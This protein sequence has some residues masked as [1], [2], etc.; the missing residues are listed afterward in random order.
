MTNRLLILVA[1]LAAS[2]AATTT[3]D[4]FVGKFTYFKVPAMKGYLTNPFTYPFHAIEERIQARWGANFNVWWN[5]TGRWTPGPYYNIAPGFSASPWL[6]D[7]TQVLYEYQAALAVFNISDVDLDRDFQW[8]VDELAYRYWLKGR[9]E[10]GAFAY[11]LHVAAKTDGAV[12]AC[13]RPVK[14]DWSKSTAIKYVGATFPSWGWIAVYNVSL[15]PQRVG[16]ITAF[17]ETDPVFI[18]ATCPGVELADVYVVDVYYIKARPQGS[19]RGSEDSLCVRWMNFTLV[20]WWQKLNPARPRVKEMREVTRCSPWAGD[21]PKTFMAAAREDGLYIYV[22]GRLH[23]VIRRG[24]LK[25]FTAPYKLIGRFTA[26]SAFIDGKFE[27]KLLKPLGTVKL[28]IG[29]ETVMAPPQYALDFSLADLLTGFEAAVKFSWDSGTYVGPG[30]PEGRLTYNRTHNIF[31]VDYHVSSSEDFQVYVRPGDVSA[32]L[33]G[34]AVRLPYGALLNGSRL[35]PAGGLVAEGAVLRRGDL[36]EVRGPASIYCTKYPVTFT[37]PAGSATVVAD[38]NTTL[39]WRPPPIVYPNGTRL[40]AD[41]VSIYVD[42]PKAVR[43]NYTRVYYLVRVSGFNGTWELWVPRGGELELPA[44][45]LGNGTRLV[46]REAMAN[47]RL[48]A[49][50]IKVEEPL[51]VTLRYGRQYLVKLE[52]PVNSTAVWADE[53]SVFK[54]GLADPWEPGNGTLFKTLLVNGTAQ[55][56]F[57]V[58]KPMTLWAQYA[59][60]YYWVEAVAPVNATRDWMPKGAVL[61]F[62]EVVDFGN[63]TRLIKPSVREAVVGGP[64]LLK[65]EYAKKQYYVKIEGVNRWEGWADARSLIRLNATVVDGVEYT[66]F[67]EV[68]AVVVIGP[69]VYRPL[70]YATYRTVARDVLGVPNPLATVKLCNAAA[71][72]GLDGFVEVGTHTTE[73]CQLAVEAFPISPYTVAGAAAVATAAALTLKRRRK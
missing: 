27:L 45:V 40:E 11:G 46:I 37:A 8:G 49:A 9:L 53:G 29:N 33:H 22:D 10:E 55:R 63:G 65:V 7:G 71:Q 35:C 61:K 2:A 64:V 23:Y 47:G 17:G 50:R 48:A 41:P 28:Y 44:A 14:V 42:G 58:D 38:A 36:V 57:R 20:S 5:V 60:V 72:A 34:R 68:D 15:V 24:G 6:P 69:G 66:P 19:I 67:D 32:R 56:E 31:G 1:L 54:V 4:G 3:L 73:L 25:L 16:Y 59:E 18:N 30:R 26:A 43:V 62:P 39:T 21:P 70:F 12:I 51:N 52:A 13:H